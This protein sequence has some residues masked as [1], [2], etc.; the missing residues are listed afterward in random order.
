MNFDIDE[1]TKK[2]QLDLFSGKR[3]TKIESFQQRLRE[4]V[5]TGS[6]SDNFEAFD[7][8]LAEGHI[9]NHAAEEL[10]K[11]K[12]EKLIDFNGVSPLVTYEKV[13]KGKRRITYK[14]IQR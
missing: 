10:K 11:M 14:R 12:K 7:F 4:K 3:L 1:D 8:T 2:V 13:F 6:I 5:L 9:G